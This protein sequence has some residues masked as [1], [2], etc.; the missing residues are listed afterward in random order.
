ML[1][2]T[3]ALVRVNRVIC[4]QRGLLDLMVIFSDVSILT[5]LYNIKFLQIVTSVQS[6]YH[7]DI[8]VKC[9]ILLHAY[10]SKALRTTGL[11]CLTIGM[12][13]YETVDI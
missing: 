10:D 7:Y 13:C 8:L 4:L 5:N 2:S 11:S 1:F 6:I 9:F 3:A 12:K